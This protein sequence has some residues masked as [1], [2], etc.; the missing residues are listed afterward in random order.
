MADLSLLFLLGLTAL[1]TAVVST[2]LSLALFIVRR[3]CGCCDDGDEEED[4]ESGTIHFVVFDEKAAVR[5]APIPVGVLVAL[6]E[7]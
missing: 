6:D 5:N 3:Q 1:T 2:T 4:G 7:A